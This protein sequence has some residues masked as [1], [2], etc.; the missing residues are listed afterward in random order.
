MGSLS[1]TNP[2]IAAVA[3]EQAEE[4]VAEH[5]CQLVR[6]VRLLGELW[7]R[8]SDDTTR[9]LGADLLQVLGAR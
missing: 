9:R 7:V 1:D 2:F 5:H 6:E 8:S 4:V 3:R